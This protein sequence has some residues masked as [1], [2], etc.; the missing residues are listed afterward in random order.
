MSQGPRV[1][2]VPPPANTALVASAVT[3]ASAV[4][5]ARI[6]S[7]R[8]ARRRRG[9][10]AI[11]ES[12]FLF[13]SAHIPRIPAVLTTWSSCTCRRRHL[14]RGR[15]DEPMRRTQPYPRGH[16]D[17]AHGQRRHRRRRPR[18]RRRFL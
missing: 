8:L 12:A 6:S 2:V 1:G 4:A 17:S 15:L 9:L 3:V 5:T 10:T 18:R 14:I 13:V 16:D 11:V 7:A